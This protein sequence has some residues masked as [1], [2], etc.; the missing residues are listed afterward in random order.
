MVAGSTSQPCDA[1]GASNTAV[2]AGP[3][4]IEGLPVDQCGKITLSGTA[5]LSNAL[6]EEHIAQAESFLMVGKSFDD[7]I[8]DYVVS[9]VLPHASELRTIE[10]CDVQLSPDGLRR[11]LH[12]LR[13]HSVC[14]KLQELS[15][16]DVH[17]HYP[18]TSQLQH[19]IMK[20]RAH[21]KRL[22]FQSCHMDDAA[23]EP[24]VEA[25]S[26]CEALEEVSFAL[27]DI[28]H[29]LCFPLDR[30]DVF[31]PAL[32]MLD[33]GSNPMKSVH[34]SGL[35]RA[36]QRCISS[37]QEIYLHNCG[38]TE[39]G[40]STLLSNGLHGSCSLRVLNISSGRL[41]HTAGKLLSSLI[42]ECPNLERL[43]VSDNLIGV[44][45]AARIS[46]VIPSAKRLSVLGLGRCHLCS[47]GAKLIAEAVRD[48]SSIRELD[49]SGNNVKDE[50]VSEICAPGGVALDVSL[51]DLS[52]NPLTNNSRSSLQAFLS[53][54]G[55]R[56][57][58][59]V[60]R[61]TG[62]EEDSPYMENNNSLMI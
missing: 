28:A 55:I 43:Y 56:P 16:S 35:S 15:F 40:L 18:E 36:C 25:I 37:L 57:C 14:D 48:S 12:V 50:D 4:A 53:K 42:T 54:R 26:Y 17:L 44:D 59:I 60:L 30:K 49:L 13:Q 22:R 51:L 39:E 24:L 29:A 62:L 21:M 23:A 33:V 31:P 47:D 5:L 58:T 52:D 45:S 46:I 27:N 3:D 9:S 11:V 7:S 1:I 8:V 32:R 34:F 19:V 10:V 38:L 2:A 41:L 20:N 6:E 61:G